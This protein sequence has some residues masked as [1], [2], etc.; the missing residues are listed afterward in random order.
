[1]GQQLTRANRIL[2]TVLSIYIYA[3]LLPLSAAFYLSFAVLL[4]GT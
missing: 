4:P 3:L 1:M 2:D